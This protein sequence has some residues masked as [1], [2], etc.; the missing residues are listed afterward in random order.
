MEI[1]SFKGNIAVREV[2]KLRIQSDFINQWYI[3]YR[4]SCF[5]LYTEGR[6]ASFALMS[7]MRFDPLHQHEEPK[8]LNYIFTLPEHRRK[9]FAEHLVKH[10]KE[11]HQ[12]TAFCSN[13]SSEKLFTKCQCIN[14][15]DYNNTVMFRWP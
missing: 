12:F 3:D 6:P 15:G 11:K 10:V 4:V 1:K 13:D 2:K 7:T 14:H 9:G 5:I 8:T